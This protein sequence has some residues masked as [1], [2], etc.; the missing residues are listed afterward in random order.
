MNRRWI[1]KQQECP[2]TK[3]SITFLIFMEV[4]MGDGGLMDAAM[5][6]TLFM[7]T[8]IECVEVVRVT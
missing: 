4:E 7:V 6:A 3:I 5:L 8:M 1:R 2:G